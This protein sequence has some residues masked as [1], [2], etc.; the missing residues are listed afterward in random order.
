MLRSL[1]HIGIDNDRVFAAVTKRK[2]GF[3][4]PPF[5]GLNLGFQT[6]DNQETV[7]QNR[8]ALINALPTTLAPMIYTYQS[9]STVLQKVL[10]KDVGRG[11]DSFESGIPADALYTTERFLP[12]GIFHADCV[13]VFLVHLHQPLI[14]IIHAGTPGSLAQITLKSIQTICQNEKV[15]AKD[16][17][18]YLGPSLDFAH[19]PISVER[20]DEILGMNR[21][22]APAIKLISGQFY[23]DVPLL[24]Y[25]Q[26][27]EAGLHPNAIRVS[28]VDTYS[29]AKEYFS[30]SR[31]EKTGRHLSFIYLK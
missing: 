11:G 23:L 3:S 13:P 16:F 22:F 12:M 10:K 6:G 19:H 18:A 25:M 1:V 27:I 28:S 15:E 5:D 31:D 17:S 30:A 2:G 9:H 7:R 26:L 4:L 8:Q 20:V 14:A 29:N 24:N 21:S